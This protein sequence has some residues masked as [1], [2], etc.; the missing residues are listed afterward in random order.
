LTRAEARI[1]RSR[2]LLGAAGGGIP[3]LVREHNWSL[4]QVTEA[5]HKSPAYISM[6]LRV[7]ETQDLRIPVLELAP[8]T[9][10]TEVVH[11]DV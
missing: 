5:I 9:P 7:F 4:R 8:M 3:L 2:Q 1:A 10:A 11:R 6:R